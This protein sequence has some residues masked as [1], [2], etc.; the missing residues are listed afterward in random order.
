MSFKCEAV[1][2]ALG[3]QIPTIGPEI[4]EK[5]GAVFLFQ[6]TQTKGG[7]MKQ[8]TIDLK[9]SPGKNFPH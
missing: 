6:I 7:P 8:W 9:N 1:I 3:G 5:V 2:R 4:C